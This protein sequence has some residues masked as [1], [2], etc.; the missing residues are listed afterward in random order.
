[1]KPPKTGVTTSLPMDPLD[2]LLSFL[3][4]SFKLSLVFDSF[5]LGSSPLTKRFSKRFLDSFKLFVVVVSSS[6]IS[7]N[8][9]KVLLLS[10]PLRAFEIWLSLRLPISYQCTPL[11]RIT[12]P[13][14]IS[15]SVKLW[16]LF[17]CLC[18]NSLNSSKLTLL[19]VLANSLTI[20]INCAYFFAKALVNFSLASSSS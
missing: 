5:R 3:V 15:I 19:P 20:R 8:N 13:H 9:R 16:S 4:V 1:M 18:I 7:L 6:W 10:N 17:E 14:S 2:D 12:Y 11:Q